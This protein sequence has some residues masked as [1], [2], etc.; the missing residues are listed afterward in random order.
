MKT[1][2][3]NDNHYEIGSKYFENGLYDKAISSFKKTIKSDSIDEY[4]LRD[5]IDAYIMIAMSYMSSEDDSKECLENA[6]KYYKLYINNIKKINFGGEIKGAYKVVYDDLGLAYQI[7]GDIPNALKYYEE[8]IKYGNFVS[9]TYIN[10]IY[11]Y[12]NHTNQIDKALNLGLKFVEFDSQNE[13]AYINLA[14]VY[15]QLNELDK[16]KKTLEDAI[17]IVDSPYK[18]YC[19]LSDIYLIKKEFEKAKE[20]ALKAL[21][22]EENDYISISNLADAYFGLG[23]NDL[24]KKYFMKVLEIE[25]GFEPAIEGLSKI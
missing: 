24:A 9:N 1:S 15:K 17:S 3:Q 11:I 19:N 18:S 20:F 23:D 22:I 4:D 10:L 16:A 6:I 5:N 13:Y 12:L 7:L 8:S 14:L 25:P 21:E 2:R